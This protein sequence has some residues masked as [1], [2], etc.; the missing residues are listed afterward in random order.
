[1]TP[2]VAA[3]PL[4]GVGLHAVG[5]VFASTCYTPQK[6]VRGWSWQTYWLTQ[7]SLCWFILPILGAIITIPDLVNVLREAPRDAMVKSFALGIGYG[8]GGTAFGLAI[9]YIGFSLTYAIAI[10]VSTV[11][12][13][14]VPPLLHGELGATLSKPGAGWVIAGIAVGTLGIAVTGVAGRL[15]ENDLSAKTGRGEFAW[16]K[17]L[18]IALAAGVLSAVYGI[19]L[20]AGA[21]IANV[22]AQHGAGMWRGN[23]VY[24][25]AN[26][27]AFLTTA[28]YCLY[29]HFK[30]KT[31]GELVELPA[32][33][34]KGSLPVNFLM[35]VIT[36]FF[37]YGQFFFYNLG[38]VHLG[39]EFDFISWAIHMTMLVLFSS[40]VGIVLR[41]WRDCRR[42][43]HVAIA[44]ALVILVGAV[45]LLG[46]GNYL[47]EHVAN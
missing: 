6:R 24:I 21:P 20:D 36:G 25:F 5:A 33:T 9:R 12:G 26:T 32:G 42:I 23:V 8:V 30:H 11:L 27:G 1:M 47:G 39:K 41:E 7:A 10:G 16:M 19:A 43:T 14:L 18:F 38:H 40:L 31:L 45:T 37:W 17:G 13:T 35:A 3:N 29:L 2:E 46:Y 44:I 4:L 22:A 15:K 34:E 28:I